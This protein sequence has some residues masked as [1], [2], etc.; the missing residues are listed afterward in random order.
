[1]DAFRDLR[2]DD[3]AAVSGRAKAPASAKAA[4]L[5]FSLSRG[6][7]GKMAMGVCCSIA[8]SVLL[9]LPYLKLAIVWVCHLVVV[10]FGEPEGS[11]KLKDRLPD[12]VR[13]TQQ[14]AEEAGIP[15][16]LPEKQPAP[17]VA[18]AARTP[19]QPKA[20]P[21]PIRQAQE[22]VKEATDE[23]K[24][25][26]AEVKDKVES[27]VDQVTGSLSGGLSGAMQKRREEA[28][29]AA[30]VA[31]RESLIRRATQLGIPWQD[32]PQEQLRDEVAAAESEAAVKAAEDAPNARC[33]L[34]GCGNPLRINPNLGGKLRCPHCK[35]HYS[36]TAA[37]RLGQPMGPGMMRPGL[38]AGFGG[39]LR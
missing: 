15:L 5:G 28:A 18:D 12:I 31:E 34:R 37:M 16:P 19:P 10:V 17:A 33:P 7:M 38:P 11:K 25:D 22:K 32:K 6:I 27:G 36:A 3:D 30:E 35:R 21:A 13:E 26:V 9:N 14:K 8:A 39:F 4:G 23:V 2:L 24:Q 1:M 20:M 29:H